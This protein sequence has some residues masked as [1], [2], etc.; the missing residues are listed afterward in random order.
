[1]WH[2]WAW[3]R[4]RRWTT[5]RL[6]TLSISYDSLW[7]PVDVFDTKA[8]EAARELTVCDAVPP[9]FV[10]PRANISHRVAPMQLVSPLLPHQMISGLCSHQLRISSPISTAVIYLELETIAVPFVDV[11]RVIR[12][13]P[14]LPPSEPSPVLT[15]CLALP[16]LDLGR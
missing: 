13:R 11:L 7:S 1:M 3:S 15:S 8:I 2:F 16:Q 4:S 10:R 6:L 14:S 5:I 9:R 12:H